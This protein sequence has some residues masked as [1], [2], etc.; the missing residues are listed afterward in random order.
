M[1][2]FLTIVLLIFGVLQII[3]FFKVWGMTNK[4]SSIEKVLYKYEQDYRYLMLIGENEKAFT[5]IKEKLTSKLI[6]MRTELNLPS[7]ANKADEIIPQ[8]IEKAQK[9]G[10]E[11]PEHLKSGKAFN[12]YYLAVGNL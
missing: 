4:V 9:T 11:L 3:L 12:D 1:I 5:L 6:D 8:Y 10:F 2:N 7:F